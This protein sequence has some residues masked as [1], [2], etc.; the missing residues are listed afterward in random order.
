MHSALECIQ[1]HK[2]AARMC[3]CQCQ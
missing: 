1:H 2:Q 3:Q